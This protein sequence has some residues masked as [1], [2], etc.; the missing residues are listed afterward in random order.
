MIGMVS[1]HFQEHYACK[2]ILFIRDRQY[3]EYNSN[4]FF[5]II[6]DM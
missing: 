1:F 5:L 3:G 2:A 6:S 4:E